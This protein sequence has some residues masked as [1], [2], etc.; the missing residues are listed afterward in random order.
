MNTTIRGRSCWCIWGEDL[1]GRHAGGRQRRKAFG[2][3][4]GAEPGEERGPQGGAAD[5]ASAGG[6]HEES[7]WFW[8]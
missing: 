8:W 7:C 4:R 1:I 6:Q 5:Q 3:P 2:G